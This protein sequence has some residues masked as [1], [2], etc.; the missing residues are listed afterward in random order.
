MG[1]QGKYASK[2]ERKEV[3]EN[4]TELWCVTEGADEYKECHEFCGK[5]VSICH[6]VWSHSLQRIGSFHYVTTA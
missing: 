6:S 4:K 3:D 5:R 2:R 1:Y